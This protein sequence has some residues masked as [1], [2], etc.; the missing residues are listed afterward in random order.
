MENSY[1]FPLRP[2]HASLRWSILRRSL[3]SRSPSKTGELSVDNPEGIK[4]ISRTS[5][6]FNLIPCHALD[7][8]SADF[9]G[10]SLQ[11]NDIAGPR[12]IY[13]CYKLPV[14]CVPE[15]TLIQRRE[16]S[17]ELND[18][19][20]ST[21]F[22]IDTTGLVC[23]WPSED[24][25]AY[26]CFNHS[27]MFRSKRVLELG[28]GYGLAGFSIAVCSDACE[29]VIS[30]GN[31]QV[32]D[33]I[34]HNIGINAEAFG[35]T[36][37]KSMLLHWNQEQ[38]SEMLNAFDIIVASDCTFFKEF[39]K[40][41]AN[42]VKSLLKRSEDSEAFFFSPKRGDSLDKFLQEITEAGLQYNLIENYDS[43]VWNLHHKFL[44]GDETS[45]PNYDKDHSYPLLLRINFPM[46]E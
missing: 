7:C 20:V 41:L 14:G 4:K 19:E 6:G 42:M 23:C 26:F 35:E 32:V 44:K 12:D 2:S 40:S 3:L 15:L 34:Q 22:D 9:V 31:P 17:I 1:T 46:E 13:V 39:H 18:F 25:L 45:W 16:D 29:V 10:T 27:D 33:Y 11:R 36:K 28:S 37:V 30:D 5:G 38:A 24:V 21:R 43:T 8:Q